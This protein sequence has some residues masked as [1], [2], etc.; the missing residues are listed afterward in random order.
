MTYT[1][2]ESNTTS[3]QPGDAGYNLI[4]GTKLVPRAMIG[5]K[6]ECPASIR[7]SLN[8]A[9]DNGYVVVIANIYKHEQTF[10]LLSNKA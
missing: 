4:D 10:N 5:I 3:L 7:D 6:K 9:I 8:W 2:H 1:I